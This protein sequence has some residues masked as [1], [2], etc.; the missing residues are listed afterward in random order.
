MSRLCHDLAI[1][2]RFIP[3]SNTS[4]I[5]LWFGRDFGRIT[6]LARGALR[7]KSFLLGQADLFATSDLVFYHHGPE[8]LHWIRECAL[9]Q[10]RPGL[11]R[12]WRAAA[13][14]SYLA[15]FIARVIPSDVP[16]PSL[17]DVFTQALDALDRA[18][19]PWRVVTWFEL[20]FL[21]M[22][23]LAPRLCHCAVCAREL[24]E[25]ETYWQPSR[26]GAVCAS[27]ARE[28][29]AASSQPVLPAHVLSALRAWQRALSPTD[30]WTVPWTAEDRAAAWRWLGDF[31]RYH[32]HVRLLSRDIAS[33][34]WSFPGPRATG[35]L[36]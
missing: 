24:G 6:V 30:P 10:P 22:E 12:E 5:V 28:S 3:W 15:D 21:W 27:C 34:W 26:G 35:P 29:G 7:P 4:R 19:D 9:I 11:R 1:A 33:E 17:F 25:E 16:Q 23:G 18:T 13:A 31:L 20:R 8:G 36:R 32:L 14:A 2:L